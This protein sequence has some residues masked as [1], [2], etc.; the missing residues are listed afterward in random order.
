MA[1]ACCRYMSLE[2]LFF[3]Q[4]LLKK[5]WKSIRDN[6]S[7]DEINVWYNLKIKKTYLM[8]VEK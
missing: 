7:T 2:K 4:V 1:M 8:C 5:F 3:D 6:I